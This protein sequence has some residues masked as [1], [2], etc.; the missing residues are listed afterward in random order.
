MFD[1]EHEIGYFMHIKEFCKLEHNM[2]VKQ[3]DN[4][5]SH[6]LVQSPNP[7][8]TRTTKGGTLFPCL[9]STPL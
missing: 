1:D 3:T 2:L 7:P 5:G 9:S 8:F 6:V 4:E